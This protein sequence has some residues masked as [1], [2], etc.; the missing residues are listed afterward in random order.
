MNY[1]GAPIEYN[2]STVARE[3]E[4][5]RKVVVKPTDQLIE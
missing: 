3:L 5:I 4:P 2:Q 1:S